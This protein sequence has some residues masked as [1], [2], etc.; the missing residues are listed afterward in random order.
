MAKALKKRN[1]KHVPLKQKRFREAQA[2]ASQTYEFDMTFC[3][4]EVNHR[5]DIWRNENN[6][7]ED[8]YCPEWLV[9]DTYDQQDLI[10][11]L[12]LTALQD[13]DYWE[14]AIS[15]HF[16]SEDKQDVYTIPF[17][18]ELPKMSHFQLM[19]GCEVKVNRGGGIKTRW[20]GLQAEMLAHW[21]QEGC[22]DGYDLI[23]SEA[24]IKAQAKFVNVDALLEHEML[25]GWR[26]EGKLISRLKVLELEAIKN[27]VAA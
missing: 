6:I 9:I 8:K 22:P 10:I 26:N 24:Y 15:S 20:K 3:I 19:S 25:L 18:I 5:L 23:K 11:A 16:L 12:K 7:T 17:Y 27:L 14:V 1:K 4:E 13:P 2:R 21:E